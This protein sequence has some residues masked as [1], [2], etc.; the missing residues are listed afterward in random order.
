MVV[1]PNPMWQSWNIVFGREVLAQHC[2]TW[3]LTAGPGVC[4]SD[5]IMVADPDDGREFAVS[6]A[7]FHRVHMASDS[8]ASEG[9]SEDDAEDDE[10]DKTWKRTHA[11]LL[12]HC[13]GHLLL[14]GTCDCR[15]CKPGMH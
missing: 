13:K 11:G 9:E 14:S 1:D 3:A 12:V 7:Q 2:D 6:R 15:K 10:D 8:E 5:P 4:G